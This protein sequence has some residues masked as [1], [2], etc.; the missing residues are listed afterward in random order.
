MADIDCAI[1]VRVVRTA[2]IAG[3]SAPQ[4]SDAPSLLV[5]A[6]VRPHPASAA[7]ILQRTRDVAGPRPG[8]CA[9]WDG[10]ELALHVRTTDPF[11]AGD[12]AVKGSPDRGG[13]DLSGSAVAAVDGAVLDPTVAS[14]R[15]EVCC[16]P[17]HAGGADSGGTAAPVPASQGPDTVAD[18]E[19]T[20]LGAAAADAEQHLRFVAGCDVPMAWITDTSS[21]LS[22]KSGHRVHRWLVLRSDTGAE[23]GR[24][25]VGFGYAIGVDP[26]AHAGGDGNNAVVEDPEGGG[27]VDTDTDDAAVAKAGCDGTFELLLQDVSGLG[28]VLSQ[29]GLSAA[30]GGGGGARFA[31]EM[32]VGACREWSGAVDTSLQWEGAASADAR[33]L[34]TAPVSDADL[35]VAQLSL[36]CMRSGGA[37]ATPAAASTAASG[38]TQRTSTAGDGGGG[39]AS[40]PA[41]APMPQMHRELLGEAVVPL[42]RLPKCGAAEPL[43]IAHQRVITLRRGERTGQPHHTRPPVARLRTYA[44][45]RRASDATT[46]GLRQSATTPVSGGLWVQVLS[47]AGVARPLHQPYVRMKLLPSAQMARTQKASCNDGPGHPIEFQGPAE[48]FVYGD[49]LAKARAAGRLPEGQQHGSGWLS[50]TLRLELVCA[51]ATQEQG[52]RTRPEVHARLELSLLSVLRSGPATLVRTVPMLEPGVAADAQQR[53]EITVR[54]QF[55]PHGAGFAPALSPNVGAPA[56]SAIAGALLI[57]AARLQ[58]KEWFPRDVGGCSFRFRSV[59][60]GVCAETKMVDMSQAAAVYEGGVECGQEICLATADA[61]CELIEIAMLDS[62][63]QV[64]GRGYLHEQDVGGQMRRASGPAS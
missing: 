18:A 17:G 39:F 52:R 40:D 29:M 42:V 7:R 43:G 1:F 24:L 56:Q 5:R 49:A 38:T 26:R 6:G 44:C 25:L 64:C 55:V 51:S 37:E 23:C 16:R 4:F 46:V 50:P 13:D 48:K 30:G 58:R 63:G 61:S 60:T 10:E 11:A 3:P 35:C 53:I 27:G 22:G 8:A 33:A 31:V 32:R 57:H 14:V 54:L 62:A 12:D 59:T 19:T 28:D 2:G 47:V 36:Y 34:L 45:V 9:S 20:A 41:P 21:D 15:L